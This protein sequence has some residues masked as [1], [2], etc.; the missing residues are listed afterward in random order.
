M[1]AANNKGLVRHLYERGWN[2]GE[3]RAIDEPVAPEFFDHHH[4]QGGPEN[5]KGVIASLRTTFPDMRFTVDDQL[6]EGDAV[7]NRWTI[8]WHR[9]GRSPRPLTDRQTGHLRRHLRRPR[10]GREDRR[11]L[12]TIQHGEA[13][14]AAGSDASGRAESLIGSYGG[15]SGGGKTLWSGLSPDG[16]KTHRTKGSFFATT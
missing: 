8:L 9:R 5:L 4:G 2:G 7:M 14:G 15:W 11:A 1:V 3:L 10:R 6:A 16:R 12:G 13:A